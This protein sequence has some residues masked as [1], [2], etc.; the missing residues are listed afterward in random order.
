MKDSALNNQVDRG[1]HPRL[2]KGHQ[3]WVLSSRYNPQGTLVA[4]TS[5]DG[6]LKLW[7]PDSGQCIRT[8]EDAE[9]HDLRLAIFSPDGKYLACY[10]RKLDPGR[11]SE[12]KVWNCESFELVLF[13]KVYGWI[14]AIAIGHDSTQIAVAVEDHQDSEDFYQDDDAIM[15]WDIQSGRMTRK[16]CSKYEADDA[17]FYQ[18]DV[19]TLVQSLE[20]NA[21]AFSPDGKYI[22]AGANDCMIKIWNVRDGKTAR[23]IKEHSYQVTDVAFS[24]NAH[25]LASSADD[26]RIWEVKTGELLRILKGN[27]GTAYHVE[28]NHDDTLLIS[29]HDNSKTV[30]VWDVN[31]GAEIRRFDDSDCHVTD[32]SFSPDGQHIAMAMEDQ[33]VRIW[34]L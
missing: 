3:G 5:H 21:I 12:V 33:T 7:D 14:N 13:K 31:T 17:I 10:Q 27:V 1:L 11:C 8:F 30:I 26:I 18:D 24:H 22:A 25:W 2:L 23:V 9:E 19:K 28:F 16:I 4:T 34:D 15:I 6:C 20:I 32:V 29:V